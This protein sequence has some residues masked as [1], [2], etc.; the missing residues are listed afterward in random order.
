MISLDRHQ[1]QQN[2][3]LLAT[4]LGQVI[5]QAAIYGDD[6]PALDTAADGF[7]ALAEA[8]LAVSG[9]VGFALA[10]PRFVAA[11]IS[12]RPTVEARASLQE[13][14][15]YLGERGLGGVQLMAKMEP[16]DIK[17]IVRVLQEAGAMSA[18]G[19]D[20]VNLRLGDL[21]LR[22][23]VFTRARHA[24]DDD[25]AGGAADPVMVGMRLY[26]RGIRAVNRLLDK[27]VSP[28]V[29]LELSRISRGLVDQ[30]ETSPQQV[31]ALATPRH[32]VPYVLRH[33]VH[34]AIVSIT[35]GHRFG[36]RDDDLVELAVCALLADAGGADVSQE[37]RDETG[38]LSPAQRAE[39]ERHPL[40]SVQQLLRLPDL[41]PRL[42]RRLLVAFEHHLGV[43]WQGYPSVARW[44]RPH[45]Y[46]RIISVADGYDAL[47]AN[48]PGRPGL[49]AAA[50]LD[51]LREEAGRRYD[52]LIV[53]HL[54]SMVSD[55]LNL[56]RAALGVTGAGERR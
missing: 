37:T 54:E 2:L 12:C 14:E 51:V 39:M 46:S 35:L 53:A 9:P 20:E 26:L 40:S 11:G 5:R 23:L 56:E 18:S 28:A 55:H 22:G 1:V 38:M 6:H 17:Q 36:L 27:G 29:V 47:K 24:V 32:L 50:A 31:L 49:D 4:R 21:G 33:P 7:V 16:A 45:P 52:P 3:V 19:P 42:R 25:A 43:D 30:L 13:L 10:A 41:H 8:L 15:T 48:R 44:I 34:M